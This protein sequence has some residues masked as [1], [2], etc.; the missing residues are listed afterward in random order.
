MISDARLHSVLQRLDARGPIN[1][2]AVALIL[3]EMKFRG[4]MFR[5]L[6]IAF[7]NA[8]LVLRGHDPSVT[9]GRCQVGMK[10]WRLYFDHKNLIPIRTAFDQLANY[11]VCCLYLEHNKRASLREML[12]AYNGKPSRLYVQ[13]FSMNLVRTEAMIA[14]HKFRRI[15]GYFAANEPDVPKSHKTDRSLTAIRSSP[16]CSLGQ[17]LDVRA[18]TIFF[19]DN[20][21]TP[22]INFH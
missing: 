9:L 6:E 2:Y 15:E 16:E 18:S 14:S 7:A 11:D 8:Y 12:I 1:S 22:K 19:D 21:E 3:T 20:S 17:S 13:S 10:Y 5:L 4:P